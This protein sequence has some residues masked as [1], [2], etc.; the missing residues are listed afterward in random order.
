MSAASFPPS[1]RRTAMSTVHW[2]RDVPAKIRAL[3]TLA[4]ADYSDI[5]T[6]NVSGLSSRTPEAWVRTGLMGVPR[7]LLF[8]IPLVQRVFLGLRLKLRPS[9]DRL[10]G[11]K[12]A[13]RGES[14]MRIEASSWFLTGHVVMHVDDDGQLSFATFV[15]Y[16]RLPAAIVWPAISLIHR[17]VALALVRSAT[18]AQ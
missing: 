1:P 5:V 17:Q 14:W 6:G 11:W 13:A 12:I 9:P 4:D 8:F 18:R 15:R 16:D 7:G 10:L 3:G 2:Q